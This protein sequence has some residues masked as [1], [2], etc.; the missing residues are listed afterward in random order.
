MIYMRGENFKPWEIKFADFGL[1]CI[2]FLTGRIMHWGMHLDFF[3]YCFAAFF[4]LGRKVICVIPFMSIKISMMQAVRRYI[5]FCRA[6]DG[7][8]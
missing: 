4:K 6:F 3:C 1:I 2:I 8:F 7:M 5:I